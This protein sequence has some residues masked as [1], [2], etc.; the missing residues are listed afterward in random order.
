MTLD[1][2]ISGRIARNAAEVFDAVVDPKK[3]SGY[4]TTIGGAS[5]PLVAGTKVTWWKDALVEVEEVEQDRRIV[6]RWD[7]GTGEDGVRYATR[8]EM[9]FEPLDDGGTLV[10]IAESGWREDE[11]G[12]RGTYLNLEGWTQMLCCMKAFVEYG[13]NL[14]EGFFLS[15]MRGVPADAP[16][17]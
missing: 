7:G 8:V 16:D 4:F 13:I 11:A 17:R 10:T 5:A 15:E 9:R 14:R 2:R 3:L 6:L 1:I 12:R